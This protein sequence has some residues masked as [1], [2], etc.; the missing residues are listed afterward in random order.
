MRSTRATQRAGRPLASQQCQG[1]LNHNREHNDRHMT[2]IRSHSTLRILAFCMM[3]TLSLQVLAGET[4][5]SM[6]AEAVEQAGRKQFAEAE[7]IAAR[8]VTRYPQ[9]REAKLT[10]ARIL[11]W[12][13]RYPAAIERF[14]QLLS[15]NPQDA[16]A[17]LGLA[18]AEYWSGDYRR[19][20]PDFRKVSE[21]SEAARA[22][23]EI[24]AASSPGYSIGAGLLSD[25]QPY[26]SL[27]GSTSL[28]LFSDPLTKWWIDLDG[29]SLRSESRTTSASSLRGGVETALPALRASVRLTAGQM[30]FP[31]DTTRLMPAISVALR[32]G[33]NVLSLSATRE[34][35][36]RSAASL[37]Q[38]ATADVL[39]LGLTRG[40]RFAI[41]AAQHRY[42]DGNRGRSADAFALFPAGRIAIGASAAWRDTDQ[43][44]FDAGVYD[45]YYTPI[46]QRE[47]RAIASWTLKRE[48]G[49]VAVHLDG[50]LAHDDIAGSFH[51]WRAV[52][53]FTRP[54]ARRATLNLAAE[55][56]S[57]AFYTSNEIRASLA[58]RF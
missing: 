54:V 20:L 15:Q 53:T 49:D 35:L 28:F 31:D 55:H 52:L 21:R 36:L 30:R 10:L 32:R 48:S 44:R 18:Q 34:P 8:A 17:R 1:L 50:G 5:Q 26:R 37:S 12:D 57:T 13:G 45:P 22:I 42:F 7:R 41:H 25:D 56:N 43:S 29:G 39:S 38:H 47:I 51:P 46:A 23:R 58:G 16:D 3:L 24:E 19:A 14:S 11:L 9:S 27:A 6:V 40:D 4:L 33:G 2:L